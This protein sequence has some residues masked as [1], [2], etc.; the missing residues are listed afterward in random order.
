MKQIVTRRAILKVGVAAST[1]I[2]FEFYIKPTLTSLGVP[3]ALAVSGGSPGSGG[4][5]G[6]G[7]GQT[8]TLLIT[9]LAGTIG[10]EPSF[11]GEGFQPNE[12]VRI[13]IDGASGQVVASGEFQ[14]SAN[15]VGYTTIRIPPV[16]DG[17]YI[18]SA[19]G[20][21]SG[22]NIST[23]Y[24]IHGI[25][26]VDTLSSVSGK[27]GDTIE[28]S[29]SEWAPGED[30]SIGFSKDGN[31]VIP[32][33][34]VRPGSDGRFTA[35][36]QVP[37]LPPGSATISVTGSMSAPGLGVFFDIVAVT[38][39]PDSAPVGSFVSV[40]ASGF[41]RGEGVSVTLMNSS[42]GI[43]SS[44][45]TRSDISG[46][47]SITFSVSENLT[48]ETYTLMVTGIASGVHAAVPFT[49]SS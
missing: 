15:G 30:V 33:G 6:S 14:A 49:V 17:Y 39:T 43:V 10:Y 40:A 41:S 18:C 42:G 9:P 3:A 26:T 25:P 46:S 23:S 19:V 13:T 12:D 48:A 29:G 16:S 35:S 47:I 45:S 31:T 1:A 4:S 22:I 20:Q 8:G 24:Y 7:Q 21:T 32:V 38:V 36:V 37:N 28:I 2:S 34:V 27:V 44:Y 11:V 5:G